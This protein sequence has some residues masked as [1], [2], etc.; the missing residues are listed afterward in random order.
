MCVCVYIYIYEFYIKTIK[1]LKRGLRSPFYYGMFSPQQNC[2]YIA[3]RCINIK[4]LA[5]CD[6]SRQNNCF[7]YNISKT[8][9]FFTMDVKIDLKSLF[10]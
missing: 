8:T 4:F 6:D 1:Y 3:T 7:I 9:Q 5:A 2:P 10:L